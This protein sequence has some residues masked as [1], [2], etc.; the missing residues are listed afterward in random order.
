V[1]ELRELAKIQSS[2][3]ETEPVEVVETDDVQQRDSLGDSGNLG[4]EAEK[5]RTRLT[6][7]RG[8]SCK[9]SLKQLKQCIRDIYISKDIY[10]TQCD[11]HLKEKETLEEH[12]W[13]YFTQ[14][15][16]VEKLIHYQ[17]D[18]LTEAT[19]HFQAIDVDVA[20]F[21]SVLHREVEAEHV[22]IHADFR[23]YVSLQ[24]KLYFRRK[25]PMKSS[26]ELKKAVEEALSSGLTQEEYEYLWS[27]ICSG[28]VQEHHQM[29]TST[30]TSFQDFRE[31]G[32]YTLSRSYECL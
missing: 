32:R 30:R 25:S 20:L 1:H 31:V 15:F 11:R 21:V 8:K 5:S 18:C 3:P 26:F 19:R 6:E 14:H 29:I 28:K 17:Y 4:R 10:D 9:W 23:D 16:G 22:H 12:L 24:L 7:V 2:V 27:V 13:R